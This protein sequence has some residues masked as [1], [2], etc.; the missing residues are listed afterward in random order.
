MASDMTII[1]PGDP[2][3]APYRRLWVLK[4][5]K[6]LAYEAPDA[7]NITTTAADIVGTSPVTGS[8]LV[9]ILTKLQNEELATFSLDKSTWSSYSPW[10]DQVYIQNL[11]QKKLEQLIRQTRGDI[12]KLDGRN[13]PFKR[14]KFPWASRGGKKHPALKGSV[15]RIVE[16]I[17]ITLIAGF[18]A[19]TVI[20]RTRHYFLQNVLHDTSAQQQIHKKQT[21]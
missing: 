10:Q 8:Q 5:I 17:A 6:G 7:R 4:N 14:I 2:E 15:G 20:P 9:K 12:N 21:K 1:S 19:V 3:S 18:I 13:N 16:G 11:N